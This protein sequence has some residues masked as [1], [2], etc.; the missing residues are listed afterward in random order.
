VCCGRTSVV[1]SANYTNTTQYIAIDNIGWLEWSRM[2]LHMSEIADSNDGMVEFLRH[3]HTRVHC[4]KNE[5]LQLK[6]EFQH[7]IQWQEWTK[8]IAKIGRIQTENGHI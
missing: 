8:N 6:L 2:T 7:Q 3:V 5:Q 4:I 1:G